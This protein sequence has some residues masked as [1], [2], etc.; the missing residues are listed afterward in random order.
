MIIDKKGNEVF[1]SDKYSLAQSSEFH[2]N[3]AVVSDK[4]SGGNYFVIDTA[5][6]ELYSVKAIRACGIM[7]CGVIVW[8]KGSPDSPQTINIIATDSSGNQLFAP[9]PAGYTLNNIPIKF[10]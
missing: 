6:K 5:G 3:R 2:E 8:A 1:I 10:Y 4:A 9:V 7:S